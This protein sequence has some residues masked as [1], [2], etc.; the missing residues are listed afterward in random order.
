MREQSVHPRLE[1]S[2]YRRR[3]NDLYA[4]VRARQNAPRAAWELWRQGRD[5]LF[6]HHPQ[7]ALEANDRRSFSQLTYFPYD[8]TWKHVVLVDESVSHEI[9]DV[10]LEADG[11]V[12]MVRIGRVTVGPVALAVHLYL[13]WILDY[14]G[15][16]FLPFRD[17]T[18]DNETFG[19][20]RYL[21]DGAKGAD[22]GW[23]DGRLILDFNFAYNPSCAYNTHWQCPLPPSENWLSLSIR[24]GEKRLS[25]RVPNP[26]RLICD[27]FHKRVARILQSPP[28]RKEGGFCLGWIRR[29]LNRGNKTWI[30]C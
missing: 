4:L 11:P 24:A 28:A 3:V 26:P 8:L 10:P 20:G 27:G 6:A 17:A 16:L 7:S 2:D 9:I 21:L 1:L 25:G 18:N 12:R 29:T 19:G 15:G 5:D 13:Y 23:E 30:R 22:L 14:G